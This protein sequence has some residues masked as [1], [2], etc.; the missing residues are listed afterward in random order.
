MKHH[1][2]PACERS[3]SDPRGSNS[4]LICRDAPCIHH[5]C[6]QISPMY[7]YT[8]IYE[9]HVC[10]IYVPIVPC[11][12]KC[13]SLMLE[14]PMAQCLAHIH[15]CIVAWLYTFSFIL[16]ISHCHLQKHVFTCLLLKN[17]R[18]RQQTPMPSIHLWNSLAKNI[19]SDIA[20]NFVAQKSKIPMKSLRREN[21]M[22][23]LSFDPFGLTTANCRSA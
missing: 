9:T 4:D 18:N 7:A 2:Q 21:E 19:F 17:S 22:K 14:W 12:H 8:C 16:Y 11:M 3:C 13:P 20:I 5:P 1:R 15:T 6:M 10:I 23:Y